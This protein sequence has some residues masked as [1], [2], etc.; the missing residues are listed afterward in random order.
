MAVAALAGASTLTGTTSSAT[1]SGAVAQ[2]FQA[3]LTLLTTQLKSQNPLDPLD[4]NQFTQQLVQFA[5]VEQQMSM[6]ESL[7]SLISLQRS[8]Q[9][10]VALGFLGST[11][12]VEGNTAKLTGGKATWS[13]SVSKPATATI[14]VQNANG[15]LLYTETRT[16]TAGRNSFTWNGRDAQG[17]VMPEGSYKISVVAKDAAGQSVSVSTEAEGVVEAI[18]L[19]QSP[20]V[21][22]V[23]G[24]S[25]TLDKIRHVRRAAS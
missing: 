9:T 20:A 14:N 2:N 17:K 12:V 18:D 19:T 22:T 21:L 15:Q 13:Y 6:N 4:T 23:N 1:S 25:Y 8:T 10:A 11:V 24:A 5:Q 16:L 3:F 7:E